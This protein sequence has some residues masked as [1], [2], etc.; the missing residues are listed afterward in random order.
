MWPLLWHVWQARHGKTEDMVKERLISVF[1]L[2][3][4]AS[5]RHGYHYLMYLIFFIEGR[6][7]KLLNS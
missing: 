6:Y 5:E 2:I 3:A 7:F 4:R 1:R